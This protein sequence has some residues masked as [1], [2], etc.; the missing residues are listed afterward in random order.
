MN[1][2]SGLILIG[3]PLAVPLV[4]TI[5]SLLAF[6]VSLAL[7]LGPTFMNPNAVV[8]VREV[9]MENAISCCSANVK[10]AVSDV[11]YLNVT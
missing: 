2:I 6:N 3:W 4:R 5:L 9:A 10:D 8:P 7:E 1:L 11:L